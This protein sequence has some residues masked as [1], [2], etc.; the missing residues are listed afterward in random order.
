MQAGI[1]LREVVKRHGSTVAVDQLSL[2]VRRGEF[3]SILGPSGSGKTTTLRLI[4]GFEHP[5]Q[6]DILIDGR[7][8][9]DAPPNLRPVNM[10]FQHYA[11]FPHLTV[12]GNVAFGLEMRGIA[13]TEIRSRVGAALDMVRLTGKEERL[14]AQLSGGEQQRVALARA[15]VNRPAVLLLDEPLGALDQQLRQEMQVELKTIQEQVGLTFICVTHHQEEALTM[16]DRVAVLDHGRVLQVG[17]PQDIYTAPASLFVAEFVGLSNRLD[18][19]IAA[20][21]GARC[22]IEAPGLPAIQA[23]VPAG[24]GPGSAVTLVVRPE[25]LHLSQQAA[26]SGFENVVPARVSKAVYNGHEMQYQLHVA[27]RLLWTVRVP[28]ADGGQKRFLPGEAVMV[29]WNRDESVVLPR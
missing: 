10:V 21:D 7:S 1:E 28:N 24:A 5:D 19:R 6:G 16:S 29:S 22:R 15:L 3:F 17:A 14:P 2:S 20:V 13:R 25:R 4:A 18:G 8:I 9:V 23:D 12:S 11:L 26:L 27:E